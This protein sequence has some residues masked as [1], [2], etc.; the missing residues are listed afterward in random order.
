LDKKQSA[1]VLLKKAKDFLNKSLEKER[2]ASGELATPARMEVRLRI[3]QLPPSTIEDEN[4]W[5]RFT[6]KAE[7]DF[8]VEI[9]VRPRVWSKL[10]AA[11]KTGPDWVAVITGT[12]GER[13]AKGFSLTGVGVQVY[14]KAPANEQE[15]DPES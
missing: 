12:I 7:C 15:K 3:T 1:P 2:L 5:R 6:L 11:S 9:R 10:I 13:T 14:E 8:E 4:G